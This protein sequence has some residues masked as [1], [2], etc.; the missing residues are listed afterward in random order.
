MQISDMFSKDAC[1]IFGRNN[2]L[3][4]WNWDEY[5]IRKKELGDGIVLVDMI[6]HPVKGSVE[7]SDRMFSG[8]YPDGT[9]F[10]LYC[11]SGGSSGYLQ[12]QL[13]PKLPQYVFVNIK[14]GIMSL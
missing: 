13:S 2:G 14:G 10:A 12:M 9:I 8:I 7:I 6:G 5:E 1:S 11:H 3:E 4:S